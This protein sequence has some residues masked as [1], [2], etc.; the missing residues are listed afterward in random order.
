MDQPKKIVGTK[1]LMTT[2]E[3]LELVESIVSLF[4]MTYKEKMRY[5]TYMLKSN[6]RFSGIVKVRNVTWVNFKKLFDAKY[7]IIDMNY[8][9]AQES[10]NLT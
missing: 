5:A 8:L 2:K 4:E 10:I 3:W 1:D 6:V 7:N 9:R